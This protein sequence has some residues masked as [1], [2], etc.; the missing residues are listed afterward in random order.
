MAAWE[1]MQNQNWAMNGVVRGNERRGVVL[2]AFCDDMQQRGTG[3]QSD[4]SLPE[5]TTSGTHSS[6]DGQ[7]PEVRG[8]A[9]SSGLMDA[10]RTNIVPC[11]VTTQP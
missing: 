6:V 3:S 7:L 10:G 5:E 1:N 4:R 11:F 8:S 2:V 9:L